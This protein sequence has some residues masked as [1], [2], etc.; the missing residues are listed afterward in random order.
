MNSYYFDNAYNLSCDICN[1]VDIIE[2]IQGY[3]CNQCGLVL[4]IL[5][6]EYHPPYNNENLHQALLNLT[7]VGSKKERYCNQK[8]LKL[9]KLNNLQNQ[10]K[11]NEIVNREAN[12]EI[13]RIFSSLQLSITLRLP[14]YKEFKRI[15]S[16][17]KSGTKLRNPQKL[18]PL[19]IYFYCK[20]NNIIINEKE[21]LDVGKISKKE[22]NSFKLQLIQFMKGYIERDRRQYILNRIFQLV[23]SF[24]LGMNFYYESKKILNKLW[25]FIKYTKDDVIA[26]VTMSISA[27][28]SFSDKITVSQIC[29]YLGIV[30][31]TIQYQVR[32]NIFGKLKISGFKSLIKSSNLL[33]KVITK[34]LSITRKKKISKKRS[35]VKKKI[36]SKQI[37]LI[38]IIIET[39]SKINTETKNHLFAIIENSFLSYLIHI[40]E[41]RPIF[42]IELIV[43][44][45]KGPPV[46]Q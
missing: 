29:K 41:K 6:L 22:Y 34:I 40:F 23:E 13:Y 15:R 28:C 31:S 16:K 32:K 9:C 8:S 44:S 25:E 21:L 18:I 5:K 19:I 26:C 43:L 38:N 2:T 42:R 39:Y 4:E 33:K 11:Y 45:G 7:S 27:I 12:N 36:H 14:I 30:M 35:K 24:S 20:Y 10:K 46:I 1:S 17:L 3:V 37:E